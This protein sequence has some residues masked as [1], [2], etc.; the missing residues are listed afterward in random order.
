L[1]GKIVLVMLPMLPAIF[2]AVG[3]VKAVS[4]LDELERKIILEAAA[5]TLVITFLG[6]I[7]LMLLKQAGVP[8]PDPG[9]LGLGMAIL[10][11]AGKLVGNWRHK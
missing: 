6:M 9:F 11:V 4:K 1:G 5:F 8:A 2:L 3:F 10:L 7:A